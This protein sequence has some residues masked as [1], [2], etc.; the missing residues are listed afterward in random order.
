MRVSRFKIQGQYAGKDG[1]T[2]EVA[3]TATGS[4][5]VRVRP[6]RSREA[7]EF[8]LERIAE[9]ICNG[10]LKRGDPPEPAPAKKGKKAAKVRDAELVTKDGQPWYLAEN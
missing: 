3:E 9:L 4:Y 8:P 6:K 5:D 10:E 1:A 7:F 2:V